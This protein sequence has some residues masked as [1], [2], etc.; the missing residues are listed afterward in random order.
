MNMCLSVMLAYSTQAVI[1]VVY[2]PVIGVEVG[3]VV[4]VVEPRG[5]A[6]F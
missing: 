2:I 1:V 6:C 4:E 5:T 3:I